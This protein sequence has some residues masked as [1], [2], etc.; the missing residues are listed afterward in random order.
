M[1]VQVLLFTI[2]Y[3]Y[4]V[5]YSWLSKK[6]GAKC[7]MIFEI[8]ARQKVEFLWVKKSD[9]RKWEQWHHWLVWVVVNRLGGQSVQKWYGPPLWPCQAWWGS[10]VARRL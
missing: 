7:F 3:N 1:S 9:R 8:C 2:E 4:L 5:K 6:H 10:W